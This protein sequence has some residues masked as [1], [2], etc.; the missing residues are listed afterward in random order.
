M[1]PSPSSAT[2]KNQHK[3]GLSP[4]K[5]R[6]KTEEELVRI[7]E[8]KKSEILKKKRLL[9]ELEHLLSDDSSRYLAATTVIRKFLS[10]GESPVIN[11]VVRAGVIP[12]LVKFLDEGAFPLLQSE[13]AWALAN[14]ASGTSDHVQLIIQLGSI[15][16]FVQLLHSTFAYAREQA[17]WAL[18][19]IAADSQDCR[20]LVLSAGALD[21]LLAQ[22]DKHPGS[23]MMRS[24]ARTLLNLC[25]GKHP[26]PFKQVKPALPALRHLINSKEEAV[27]IDTCRA[28]SLIC[29]G[30]IPTIQ[31]VLDAGFCPRLL[32]LLM[33]PSPE[34]Q[35]PTLK[36]V[37]NIVAGTE[38]QTQFVIDNQGLPPLC[39]ILTGNWD[40]SIKEEACWVIANITAGNINQIQAVIEANIIPPLVS[41]LQHDEFKIKKEAAWA[42]SY[43]V[44]GG[45]HEQIQYLVSQGCIKPL[46]DLLTCSNPQII[47]LCLDSVESILESGEGNKEYLRM[48]NGCKGFNKIT[49]LQTHMN[50]EV[51][52]QASEILKKYWNKKGNEE[53]EEEELPSLILDDIKLDIGRLSLS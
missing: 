39:Q 36:T 35:V 50:S 30:S 3:K 31:S 43:A 45:S 27:L 12:R 10:T 47:T 22:L 46:C 7:R 15:P 14:I 2:R 13:A 23:T 4:E 44:S 29:D 38:A 42:I 41:L 34:V 37:G 28:L 6:S 16:K 26:P 49:D 33:H 19:N 8:E 53:E 18:A 25:D 32:E 21:L 52:K 51:N 5:A 1:S 48:I 9:P 24:I 40:K 11:A 20:D 17:I